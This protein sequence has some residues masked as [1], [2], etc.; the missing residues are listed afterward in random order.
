VTPIPGPIILLGLPLLAAGL[1]YLLRRWAI[2]AAFLSAATTASLALLCLR[3]PLD[4]S[5][6]VLG[7]EVAFGLPVVI[8]G[9]NL[10]LEPAGQAWL[11]F[12]FA[13]STIFFLF[14]WRVSQGRSFF[15]FSLAILGLYALMALVQTFSIA[16]MV[17]AIST[18]LA[19]FIIQGGRRASIRGAQRYLVVTLLAVPLLLTAAWFVD[20]SVLNPENRDL[21]R[22]AL[23]P[24]VIG[25]GLLLA[26]FPFGTWMATMAA[27]AA[28][29]VTAFIFTTGQAMAIFL[30]LMFF[31]NTPFSLGDPTANDAI[32]LI[33]LIMAASGG[34]MAAVQRDLGRLFGYAALGDLGVLLLA[35]P[36][37]GSQR[38]S[39]VSIHMIGRAVSLTLLAAS[40]SIVRH[41]ATTDRFDRLAGVARRLP[42]ATFGFVLGVLALAG[43]PFT[44]GFATHW[45][46][47]RTVWNWATPLSTLS[48]E[49]AP[50]GDAVAVSQ[51][52]GVLVLIAILASSAGIAVGLLRGLSAMLVPDP[53][54]DMARQP[55]IASLMVVALIALAIVLSL[56][57]QLFLEPIQTAAQAFSGS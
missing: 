46:I 42:I 7:Q 33:G 10:A 12:I 13:L 55:I 48:G 8:A 28:P 32:L 29:V 47:S 5:A 25:F 24:A 22:Q 43:F 54:D 36:A 21:I 38:L 39:L 31:Q 34:I 3:L 44:P 40:L 49:A 11:A 50:I 4:R 56:Y 9:R 57:P 53:R 51:W 6:I 35:F 20:Q 30:V 41:R 19:A 1:T 26:A 16:V 23:M 45:A 27:D 17:F 18:T 14:A 37:G 2:L 52:T 15:P